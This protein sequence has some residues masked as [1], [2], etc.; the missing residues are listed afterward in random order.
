[1][2]L[3]SPSQNNDS[4]NG[5]DKDIPNITIECNNSESNSS[6]HVSFKYSSN[7][8]TFDEQIT[9]NQSFESVGET[10]DKDQQ[11]RILTSKLD[12]SDKETS[13]LK[14]EIERLRD[15]LENNRME[16]NTKPDKT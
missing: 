8:Q 16:C 11:I 3:A 12:A 13:E 7:H 1:M 9:S 10:E 4:S 5:L 2:Q 14:K 15:M 6:S